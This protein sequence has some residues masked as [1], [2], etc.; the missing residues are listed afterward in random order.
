M[1]IDKL[2]PRFLVSDED[3][4]LLKEGA[5]TDALNVSI[6][7]DGAGSEGVLKNVK[8]T[9]A[10]SVDAGS[11]LGTGLTVIGQVSDS[12][13][14]F[15]YFFVAG[16]SAANH[17]IYQYNTKSVEN[18]GLVG[19]TYREVFKNSWLNFQSSGFVKADVLNGAFQQDGVIQTILYFTDNDNEPRKIN[20]NRALDG[21][22]DGLI[23]DELDLCLKVVRA[24]II[25]APTFFFS[26]DSSIERNNFKKDYFQFATQVVY[27]DGEESSLS[28]ISKLAI[29]RSSYFDLI[30]DEGIGASAFQDNVCNI[31]IH[32]DDYRFIQSEVSKV[33]LFGRSGNN[34]SFFLIDSFDPFSNLSRDLYGSSDQVYNAS[35]NVYKFYNNSTG[36]SINTSLFDKS[37]DNVPLKAQGQALSA[38]RLFFS[39]YVE[40]F[41]NHNVEAVISPQYASII[42]E[43]SEYINAADDSTDVISADGTSVEINLVGGDAFGSGADEQTGVAFSTEVTIEFDYDPIGSFSSTYDEF[44]DGV[45]ALAFKVLGPTGITDARAG[46]TGS[47]TNL[48]T[49]L[50]DIDL[51]GVSPNPKLSLNFITT[52]ETNVSGLGTIIKGYLD[53]KKL[54]KTY[55]VDVADN[56]KVQALGGGFSTPQE[57]GKL[58][59]VVDV[60]FDM[61][62]IVNHSPS[63]A[64]NGHFLISMKISRVDLGGCV[65]V[66]GEDN[67]RT[68]ISDGN[69]LRTVFANGSQ[70]LDYNITSF[71]SNQNAEAFTREIGKTFKRGSTYDF[72]VVYYD[73][74][75]RSS[76][77]NK[78]G[79]TYIKTENETTNKG[80]VSV[81]VSF[82]NSSNNAPDWAERYKIVYTEKNNYESFLQYTV[83]G[84]YP[85]RDLSQV[86]NN[87]HP[88]DTN[89]KQLYVS[90]KTLDNYR[91]DKNPIRDYSFTR[92]D[93]LRV[94]SYDSDSQESPSESLVYP[95]ANDGTTEIVFDVVGVSIQG[96]TEETNTIH[97]DAQSS[98]TIEEKYQGTFLIL[99]SPQVAA[100]VL[101]SLGTDSIKYS[102][103]DWFSVTG[104][105]YPGDSVAPT[106][107]NYWG[108]R[109]VVEILTPSKLVSEKPYYEFGHS[110]RIGLSRLNPVNDHGDASVIE[111]NVYF[112]PVRCKTPSNVGGTWTV[113]T[114]DSWVYKTIYMESESISDAISSEHWDKGRSYVF[115]D[116]AAEVR[117]TNGITYSDA[118]AEDV[119]S[120]SLSSFNVSLANFDSLDGRYG[121]VEYIG[122][123]NDD[124]V[125]LQ[126]NKL[127]LIPVNKNIL[128]YASGSADVAVSTNVLGQRRYS[129]G[130]YGSG[131]HPEAVLIQD[132][133]VY[134][135]DESRQA[136]CALTGGQLVPISEKG[137]SSFFEGFFTND[138]T[139]YVSGYDPRDNTYY[140]TGLGGTAE[141]IGYD[142]ARGVWQSR[143]SFTPDVYANQN[144]MLYSA[145]YTDENNIFWKHDSTDYNTFYGDEEDSIVQ[146]VSKLSPSRVKVFN[147]ISYEGDDSG[148]DMNPGMQTSLGQTSETITQWN[149]KEGSY[150]ASVPRNVT[151]AEYGSTSQDF[152]VGTLTE[153]ATNVYESSKN[154]SRILLPSTADNIEVKSSSAQLSSSITDVNLEDN[155]ITIP[156]VGSINGQDCTISVITPLKHGLGD[157]MRGHWAKITLTNSSTTKHELYCINTHVTDSK[158]HHPL[159]Q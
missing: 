153:V 77:V 47:D 73:K 61:D 60:W 32:F 40:G 51:K 2:I 54:V 55:S 88:V 87:L 18:E 4:R 11:E 21:E 109:C 23:N 98:H 65:F 27:T 8:G 84:A 154:L 48:N 3:E 41:A 44:N 141:T 151:E 126:E 35:N 138:H 25:E 83:G 93:K 116:K 92:G 150:Y 152:F 123:Y 149:E 49:K 70:S 72:G 37:Y 131:G 125:A 85:V 5:M 111:G 157:Y 112:R 134:F 144:N 119:A 34:G 159:G 43:D 67:E 156:G 105:T 15:I 94:I 147:A 71:L 58:K 45:S 30:E 19:N 62:S 26:S 86:V 22:Y 10:A 115:Y 108:R 38:N 20:V 139:K 14:G 56:I 64:A 24:P 146:V 52:E 59:G 50:N 135:V 104:N 117:R 42:G 12:Q 145:K 9:T 78:I 53:G 7:E 95:E 28:P 89:K 82:P 13:R 69:A 90:L 127:C 1:P 80:P 129:A 91:S 128:E 74:F 107:T 142:A 16:E 36:A 76:F 66:D 130:D 155:T 114:P 102:G 121:A 118:Y 33:N 148:W 137:M 124:L 81:S 113:G 6:S 99:E 106:Q 133:S 120:L 122:N 140:V 103:F 68:I 29:A 100:G 158:S 57:N 96:D 63:D 46:Y 75:G 110:K 143:Y 132:N 79:S 17:A 39:N 136:V 101:N 31:D 97:D